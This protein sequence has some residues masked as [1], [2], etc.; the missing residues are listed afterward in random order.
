VQK[1]RLAAGAAL[2][3]LLASAAAYLAGDAAAV[4]GKD[5]IALVAG[6]LGQ[7]AS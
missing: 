2:V 5:M 4:S 1:K 3:A 6:T 7:C